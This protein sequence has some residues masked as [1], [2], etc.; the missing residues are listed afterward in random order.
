MTADSL[1]I[2]KVI[3]WDIDLPVNQPSHILC[4]QKWNTDEDSDDSSEFPAR[5]SKREHHSTALFTRLCVSPPEL[6][7]TLKPLIRS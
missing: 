5:E 4:E 7:L 6:A 1:D 2:L 3:A